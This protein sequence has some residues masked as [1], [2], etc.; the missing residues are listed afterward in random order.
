MSRLFRL[1]LG[2]PLSACPLVVHAAT[3]AHAAGDADAAT[4]SL[5]LIGVGLLGFIINRRR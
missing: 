2:I 1:L 4:Y 3:V 5:A